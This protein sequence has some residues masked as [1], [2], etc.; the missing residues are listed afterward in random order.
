MKDLTEKEVKFLNK[1]YKNN[2]KS[3]Y[4]YIVSGAIACLGLFG[5]FIG[6]IYQSEDGFLMALFF[7]T[8][9]LMLIFKTSSDNKIIEI[10]KK[11][12]GD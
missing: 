12:R 3:K 5:F 9:S 4:V 11:F 8:I 1:L 6:I 7:V 10:I 2:E